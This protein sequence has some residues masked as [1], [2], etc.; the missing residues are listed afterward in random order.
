MK[1]QQKLSILAQTLYLAN[2]LAVPVISLLL[3]GYLCYRNKPSGLARIHFVRAIQ[4]SILNMLAI[5]VLP[6]LYVYLSQERGESMMLALFYF[7]CVHTAFVMLGMLNLSRAM[8]NKLP[9]F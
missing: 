1:Q 9:M 4:L 7:V 3:L 2:L 8:V 6:L 5:G